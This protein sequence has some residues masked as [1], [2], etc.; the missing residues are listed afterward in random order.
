MDLYVPFRYQIT[1]YDCVPTTLLNALSYLFPRDYIPPLVIQRIYLYCLDKPGRNGRAGQGGTSKLA[2]RH[3]AEWLNEYKCKYTEAPGYF[4]V[5]AEF[6][7][8]DT[9]NFTEDGKI[10]RC[11]NNQGIAALSVTQMDGDL[12]YILAQKVSH[13]WPYCFDPYRL[14][15]NHE[16]RKS[17]EAYQFIKHAKQTDPN[18]RIKLDWIQGK[19][20]KS[21]N[22]FRL[23]TKRRRQCV[24]L[25]DSRA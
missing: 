9:V 14:R 7:D 12:H 6:I 24:L 3:V 21:G 17:N 10:S 25:W 19:S 23:G 20:T 1:D 4:S 11:L 13:G 2:I 16:S 8:G 22:D 18:L 15:N 5:R